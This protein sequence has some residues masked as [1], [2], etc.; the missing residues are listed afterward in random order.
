M[1]NILLK[2]HFSI[3]SRRKDL[4]RNEKKGRKRKE[5]IKVRKFLDKT[6]VSK[7]QD[8]C[9]L[10]IFHNFSQSSLSADVSHFNRG[11]HSTKEGDV[12]SGHNYSF[13]RTSGRFTNY[14]WSHIQL[15]WFIYIQSDPSN[16][17]TV[18]EWW[19]KPQLITSNSLL[20]LCFDYY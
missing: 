20:Q 18:V 13:C 17:K 1:A 15:T 7:A 6:K 14:P 4:K 19:L 8:R 5:K 16:L 10:N 3:S 2:K 9:I 12:L 11:S